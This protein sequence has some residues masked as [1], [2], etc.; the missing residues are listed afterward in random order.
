[1]DTD[2]G[3]D[4]EKDHSDQSVGYRV[5]WR[6]ERAVC[7]GADLSPIKGDGN[8]R[9]ASPSTKELIDDHI[10]RADPADER[11]DAEEGRDE[12]REP[13]PGEGAYKYIEEVSV[14]RDPPAVRLGRVCFRMIVKTV[15]K[16]GVDQTGGP[17]HG[18]GPYEDLSEKTGKAIANH[19]R[20]DTKQEIE[21]PS[22]ILAIEALQS[23][24]G[25]GGVSYTSCDVDI[26]HDDDEGVLLDVERAI[27]EGE[28]VAEESEATSWHC[29]R[30]C[31]SK[32][33]G[34][35]LNRQR[36]DCDG[37]LT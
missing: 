31:Y 33:I 18:G 21:A 7:I 20:R 16:S 25:V 28:G 11:E 24:D 8:K 15:E 29:V 9:H 32:R 23:G 12:A 17:D 4:E 36:C 13:V 19:L 1:M 3:D 10:I 34:D 22:E 14:S 26:R 2:A 37:R 27:V 6:D 30:P 5:P 35:Q